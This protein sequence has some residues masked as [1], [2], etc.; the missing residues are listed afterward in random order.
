ML[1]WLLLLA[2]SL[3]TACA[4]AMRAAPVGVG[5]PLLNTATARGRRL[6]MVETETNAGV[7]IDSADFAAD[8]LANAWERA[9][10]GKA[11]WKPGDV[12]GDSALDMR[13]LY[14]NWVLNPMSL[15]VREGC[16]QSMATRLLM[17]WL[18]VPHRAVPSTEATVRLDGSGVPGSDPSSNAGGLQTYGE[19]CSF[20]VAVAQSKKRAVAPATGREDVA[21]WLEAPSAATFRP[22]LRGIE[23]GVQGEDDAQCLN[24]WGLSMDDVECLPVLKSLLDADEGGEHDD[25]RAYCATNY[26]KA[27]IEL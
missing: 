18:G 16:S 17:G 20:V 4:L 2:A 15:Y 26:A 21:A 7:P 22:L 23:R 9:G 6:A 25:L 14:S 3:T 24:A 1:R 12:T 27:G 8:E 19:I 5:C 11:R 13:L 10:K